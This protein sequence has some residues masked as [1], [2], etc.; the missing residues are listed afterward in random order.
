MSFYTSLF[1]TTRRFA[2]LAVFC[3][4]LLLAVTAG[5]DSSAPSEF[6]GEGMFELMLTSGASAGTQASTSAQSKPPLPI[7]DVEEANVTISKVQI[8]QAEAADT[9]ETGEPED[10]GTVIT[11]VDSTQQFDLLDLQGG[12]SELLAQAELEA[13][14]YEQLRLVVADASVL[15]KSG[16]TVDVFVPSGAQTGIKVLLPGLVVED[17]EMEEVTLNFSLEDSFI[18]RGNPDAGVN[19]DILLKPVIKPIGFSDEE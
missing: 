6:E 12:V 17:G 3:S 9:T 15:L 14:I 8:V 4:L 10:E 5:C 11:L 19:M 13:G 16:D 1:G 7:E 18:V 2:S